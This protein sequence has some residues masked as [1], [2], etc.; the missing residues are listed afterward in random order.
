MA[1]NHEVICERIGAAGIIVLNRPQ[2]LNALTLDMSDITP[3]SYVLLVRVWD[4]EDALFERTRRIEVT[5]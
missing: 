3:G 5:R 4:H 2:A 1:E